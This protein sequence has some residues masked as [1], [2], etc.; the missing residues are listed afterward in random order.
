MSKNADNN[1]MPD[2]K[3]QSCFFRNGQHPQIQRS[4]EASLANMD[5]A[6]GM[7]RLK[8][9]EIQSDSL[10][11]IAEKSVKK[12]LQAVPLAHFCGRRRLIRRCT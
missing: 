2:S 5:I 8:G 10:K 1:D 6:V 4:H 7:L 9:D 3:A 11:E 12:C